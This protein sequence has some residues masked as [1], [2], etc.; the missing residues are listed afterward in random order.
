MRKL[1]ISFCFIIFSLAIFAA[2]EKVVESSSRKVPDWVY[3][4][5]HDYI[6]TTAEGKTMEVARELAMQEVKE[7]IVS[8]VAEHVESET[9]TMMKETTTDSDISAYTVFSQQIRS[10]SADIPFINDISE[11]NVEDFYWEKVKKKDG[12]FFYRYNIKYPFSDL[13]VRLIIKDFKKHQEELKQASIKLKKQIELFADEDFKQYNS[14]E[15]MLDVLNELNLFIQSVPADDYEN[16]NMCHSIMQNYKRMIGSIQIRAIKI[17]R[18]YVDYELYYGSQRIT[19]QKTP[20][21]KSSCLTELN[22]VPNQT[23]ARITYNF[24]YGCYEGDL[25]ELEVAYSIAGK[26]ISTI[27]TIK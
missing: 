25:N 24:E 4:M 12:T 3:S 14:V 1:S 9:S 10:K 11:A 2:S 6:I 23:G 20:R 21:I 7:R 16:A 22:F 17:T 19:Y 13:Q 8:S 5:Q 15:E 18:E 27:F 26:K